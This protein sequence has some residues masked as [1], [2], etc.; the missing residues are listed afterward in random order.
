MGDAFG[1]TLSYK[2]YEAREA[3]DFSVFSDGALTFTDD[4][5]MAIAIVRTLDLI[6]GIDCDALAFQFVRR[7]QRDPDRGYG[8]MA[9]R[10]LQELAAG[11]DWRTVSPQAFG[12][13]S[14]GNGAAMRVAPLGAYFSG[15][16][17]K[18]VDA[19][20]KSAQV[21]H[22]HPEGVAGAIAVALAAGA[23]V[24]FRGESG[25]MAAEAIQ[26][27]VLE[28]TPDSKTRGNLTTAF[29]MDFDVEPSK[30]ASK[31]GNGAEITAQDTVPFCLWNACRCL[32]DFREAL[33]F[34]GR[35]RR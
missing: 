35:S 20:T 28:F 30:V 7:F 34:D 14:F 2:F 19:A 3:A 31:V 24:Q 17:E 21:T 6:G 15:N 10:I 22:Y 12:A 26:K 5:E 1:E 13:G 32:D 16:P 33:F 9:R 4:T 11:E 29:E 27:S 8:K 23:A 25:K 18:I